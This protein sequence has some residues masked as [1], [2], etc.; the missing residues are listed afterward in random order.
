MSRMF[1]T[2]QVFFVLKRS[3]ILIV[4]PG[5]E[6]KKYKCKANICSFLVTY[7]SIKMFSSLLLIVL[8][9]KLLQ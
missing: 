8:P 1:L 2:E 6:N 5:V 4:V 7:F 9:N 3:L